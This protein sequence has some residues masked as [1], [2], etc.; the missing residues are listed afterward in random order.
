MSCNLILNWHVFFNHI[1][2]IIYS[3]Y[4]AAQFCAHKTVILTRGS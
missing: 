4:Y 1:L 2:K 3:D